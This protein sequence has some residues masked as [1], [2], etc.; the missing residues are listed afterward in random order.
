MRL[1]LQNFFI[2]I[3]TTTQLLTTNKQKFKFNPLF[4]HLFFHKNYPF[5][6]KKIYLSQIP[7]LIN[8]T[9]YI[10]PII[11]N[12]IIHSHNNSTSKF[13]P[14]YIK[15]KHKINPQITLHHL[16]N[17]NPQ[18]LTNPTYHHHHIII[19]NIHNKKLT[20]TQIKKIQTISTILKNKYTITNKT[21]NP[22]KININHNKKNNITQSNNTK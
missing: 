2:S 6:T 3:Y 21:F 12:K 8:I 1:F 10:S 7:K 16:P 14:K 17:K 4:L 22:I 5:T 11:S 9:L 15:P 13:T 19:Q 18:N 20:I